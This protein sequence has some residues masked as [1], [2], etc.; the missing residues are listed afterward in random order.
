MKRAEENKRKEATRKKEMAS[1]RKS[2]VTDST[3]DFLL[4]LEA[5]A[6][7]GDESVAETVNDFK[8]WRD[9]VAELQRRQFDA[10]DHEAK[11]I[12]AIEEQLA[13]DKS[14]FR[15]HATEGLTQYT[16]EET[17]DIERQAREAKEVIQSLRNQNQKMRDTAKTMAEEMRALY[18][19]NERLKD[20][21]KTTVDFHSQLSGFEEK[22][23]GKEKQL[24]EMAAKYIEAIDEHEE[25]LIMRAMVGDSE[26]NIKNMYEKLTN[27][28]VAK[29]Q[30]ECNDDVLVL[31]LG[32]IALGETEEDD[33]DAMEVSK[34]LHK[35]LSDDDDTEGEEAGS[36]DEEI[37]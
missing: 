2:I 17:T 15:K 9:Y 13:R 25:A 21:N 12:D 4:E 19:A 32:S 35:S 27:D 30:S 24:E 16:E 14:S 34:S 28:L 6:A 7:A 8:K 18:I 20:A 1:K 22:E 26:N 10:E 23:T 3:P 37:N 31:E 11:Q 29:F 36:E 5:D 33:K